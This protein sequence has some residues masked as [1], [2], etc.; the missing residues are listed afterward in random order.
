M[1]AR[2]IREFDNREQRG[3]RSF[4]LR[5]VRYVH[6]TT[7]IKMRIGNLNLHG[8]A[9]ERGL[10]TRERNEGVAARPRPADRIKA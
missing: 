10:R 7:R 6:C 8:I 9:H 1:G 2:T 4:R 5:Q 3:G